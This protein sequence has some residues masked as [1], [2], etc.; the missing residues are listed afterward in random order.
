MRQRPARLTCTKLTPPGVLPAPAAAPLPEPARK[1]GRPSSGGGSRSSPAPVAQR[2]G[3]S[4]AAA[5]AG[6]NSM[7]SKHMNGAAGHFDVNDP[8]A[9]AA[10]PAQ[11]PAAIIMPRPGAFV[12]STT[13]GGR[14]K[15]EPGLSHLGAAAAG[16]S[17]ARQQ[18]PQQTGRIP[19]LQLPQQMQVASQQRVQQQQCTLLLVPIQQQQQGRQGQLVRL[20]PGMQQKLQSGTTVAATA[21]AAKPAGTAVLGLPAAADTVVANSYGSAAVVKHHQQQQQQGAG[22]REDSGVLPADLCFPEMP[23]MPDVPL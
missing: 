3:N 15:L 23:R 12:L 1:V 10:M 6:G 20:M 5:A 16:P 11:L 17:P 22:C 13:P 8:A 19:V 21:A 14:M 9:L 7:S 2:T 4:P 18:Q